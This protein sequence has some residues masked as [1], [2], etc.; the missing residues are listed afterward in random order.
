MQ[1][2]SNDAWQWCLTVVVITLCLL[3][4]L[5]FCKEHFQRLFIN[6]TKIA[7]VGLQVLSITEQ[8]RNKI[9]QRLLEKFQRHTQQA[10]N[11]QLNRSCTTGYIYFCIFSVSSSFYLPASFP[12]CGDWALCSRIFSRCL[13]SFSLVTA[14]LLGWMP[15]C[16]VVP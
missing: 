10:K 12:T 11:Q 14:A 8:E 15:T 1:R 7:T 6:L 16:T 4:L 13:S 3:A 9:F 5:C 2:I